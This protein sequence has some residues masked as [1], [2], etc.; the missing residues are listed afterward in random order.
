MKR[1][2]CFSSQRLRAG[3]TYAAPTALDETRILLSH[4]S[5]YALG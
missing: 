3:L 5:A 1:R 2:F 4:P